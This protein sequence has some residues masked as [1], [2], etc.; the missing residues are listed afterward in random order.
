MWAWAQDRRKKC[1]S[2]LAALLLL[3][4]FQALQPQAGEAVPRGKNPGCSPDTVPVLAAGGYHTLVLKGDGTVWGWGR[5]GALGE[6]TSRQENQLQ[7]VQAERLTGVVSLDA[8]AGHSV[9]LSA[10]GDV[11]TWG[12]GLLGALGHGD[13]ARIDYP[14]KV[15]AVTG[16]IDI[17]AGS[18]F[19]LA[20]KD[21]GSVWA[22]GDN[23]EGQLGDGTGER[24][25]LP[26][27][28]EG[29]S[30]VKAVSAGSYHGVALKEDGTVWAWGHVL[31]QDQSRTEVPVQVPEL[32]GIVA[33]EAGGEHT[34]ALKEDGTVWTWGRGVY[35]QLG[36][37]QMVSARRPVQIKGFSSIT[38]LAAGDSH[39][40]ALQEDGTVWAWG[41]NRDGQLGTGA[42]VDDFPWGETI[43]S[44]VQGLDELELA[45]LSAG[46]FAGG[47]FSLAAS[48][49]CQIVLQVDQ[50]EARWKG[51]ELYAWGENQYGQL[52]DGT[53]DLQPEPVKLEFDP[54]AP[55]VLDVPPFIENDR[56]LVPLRF[57]G[58]AMGA[59]FAWDEADRRVT[60]TRDE[61]EIVLWIDEKKALLNGQ[62]QELD[63][64][65]R[66]VRN[67]TVVPLRFVGEALGAEFHWDGEN[68]RITIDLPSGAETVGKD[69]SHNT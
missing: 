67:R 29:L 4:L 44:Q 60:Y 47:V 22:W 6:G 46:G 56:T 66:I 35:G 15:E 42:Q 23:S 34:L 41:Y 32:D 51:L 26:V 62:E 12:S 8:S 48:R 61:Q 52:G 24:Q 65:P 59:E 31:L 2:L 28:V 10:P 50:P 27:Q 40:L 39:S 63:V 68:R 36:R 69:D 21:D 5:G 13:A 3:F 30:G 64:S 17:A 19:T 49:C 1:L 25:Y 18:S 43:P 20:V 16:V 9:A 37:G 45:A 7:P 53:R 14:E 11:W 33:V 57:V 54:T 55:V 38:A 58:E